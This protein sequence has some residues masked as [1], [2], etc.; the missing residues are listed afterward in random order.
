MNESTV[1]EIANQQLPLYTALR[2]FV[3]SINFINIGVISKVH[4]ENYVDVNLYYTDNTGKKVTIRAVR[5]LHVGTTKCKINITPAVGDNVL[6]I[7]PKDFV[8]KLQ[9]NRIPKKGSINYLP[10]GNINMCGILVKAE[11]DDNVKT[12]VSIDE[13]GNVNVETDGN[14]NVKTEGNV[15]AMCP[16]FVIKKDKN[17]SPVFEVTP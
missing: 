5:L 15:V 13:N 12:T 3:G 4:S 7:T 16:S 11:G 10:Y 9:Y 14:V 2:G 17:S 8:E 6:L 1:K